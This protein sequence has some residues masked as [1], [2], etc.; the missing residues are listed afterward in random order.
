MQEN[1]SKTEK[2]KTKNRERMGNGRKT[3]DNV[4]YTQ[5]RK[6]NHVVF[7]DFQNKYLM[8]LFGLSIMG[9]VNYSWA[10][11]IQNR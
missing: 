1:I 6:K 8:F 9:V 4:G 2:K 3:T 5:K 7:C 11:S 10:K